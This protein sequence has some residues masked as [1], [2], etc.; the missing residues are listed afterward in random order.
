MHGARTQSLRDWEATGGRTESPS[1][2]RRRRFAF[3]KR[4]LVDDSLRPQA[5]IATS[6]KLP[7]RRTGLPRGSLLRS[8]RS[9]LTFQEVESSRM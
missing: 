8:G 2:C 1:E 3:R 6:A 9:L 7:T 4:L 5:V